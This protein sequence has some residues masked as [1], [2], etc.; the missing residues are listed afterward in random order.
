M[1][2][3]IEWEKQ[4]TAYPKDENIIIYVFHNQHCVSLT[5]KITSNKNKIINYKTISKIT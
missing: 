3:I 5:L 2:F 1:S 4:T